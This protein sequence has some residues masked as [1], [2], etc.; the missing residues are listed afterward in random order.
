MECSELPWEMRITEIPSSRSAPNRRFGRCRERAPAR[1][2]EM[3]RATCSIMVMPFT[4]QY[5]TSRSAQISV[6]I[7]WANVL[8]DPVGNAAA[9][10]EPS[11]A[12]DDFGQSTRSSIAS[13]KTDESMTVA[14]GTR[15]RIGRQDDVHVVQNGLTGISSAP[16]N[17]GREIA[18][19]AQMVC[20]P[21]DR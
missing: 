6:P 17:G 15:P 12:E 19:W 2:L 18:A 5:G 4:G 10:A 3:I 16:N 7:F 1:P 8:T 14:S 20:T 9:T 13:R 11:Y 21:P